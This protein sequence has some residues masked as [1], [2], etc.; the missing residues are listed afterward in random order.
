MLNTQNTAALTHTLDSLL[1]SNLLTVMSL[2]KNP[3]SLLAFSL[4]TRYILNANVTWTH[5]YTLPCTLSCCV[6][7]GFVR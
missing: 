3:I 6:E 7:V 1:V 2:H 5:D 4:L